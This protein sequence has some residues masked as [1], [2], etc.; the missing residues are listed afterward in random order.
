VTVQATAGQ[1]AIL[2]GYFYVGGLLA[3]PDEV[4]LDI[5]YGSAV[6]L[7]PDYAGPYEYEGASSPVPGQVWRVSQGVYA[8]AWQIPAA[9]PTG[10]YAANWTWTLGGSEYPGAETVWVAGATPVPVPAGD[11]G[12]WTGGLVYAA[13]GLD[14][15]FGQVDGDGTAWLWQ[16]ITGWD[17]PPVQGAGVIP[18]SGDHGAYAAP[19]YYAARTLTLTCTASAQTQALRDAA[20]AQLQQ[21]V[22]VSDLCLLRYDEPVPKQCLVRRSGTVTEAYPTLADVT[23]TVGLVAPDPRK[24]G[25]VLKTLPITPFPAN[26]GGGLVV[27]FTVPF[28]LQAA[29][30]PATQTVVN[31]G[32]FASPPIAVITGPVAG[33]QL[34]CLTTGQTVSWSAVTLAGGQEMVIDFLNKQA[35]IGGTAPTMPGV[36]PGGTYAPADIG[37]SW[38]TLAP[39]A[40]LVQYSGSS[41]TGS[42]CAL[43]W[44]DAWS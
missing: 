11:V 3:D 12:Y 43:S 28:T 14:I 44:R 5:T 7:V 42:K 9:A 15:E 1:T 34:A 30:P 23:F 25:T 29:S 35:W 39:G 22:P 10:A 19:Q 17:S 16:K 40:S 36:P 31:A 2:Y 20:R 6:G 24:Y 33:P 32:N 13:A 37:S 41:E 21:A 8:V 38:W 27:P 4:Q 26:P 18:R